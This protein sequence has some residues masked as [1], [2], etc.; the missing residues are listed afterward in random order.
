[1]TNQLNLTKKQT[2]NT[3]KCFFFY[4]YFDIRNPEYKFLE[5]T[6]PN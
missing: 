2:A 6:S 3:K 5:T 4:K 1:M